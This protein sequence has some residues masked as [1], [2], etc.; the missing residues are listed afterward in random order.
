MRD[1]PQLARGYLEIAGIVVRGA[2]AAGGSVDFSRLGS[3]AQLACLAA[4]DEDLDY[5][6]CELLEVS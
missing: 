3:F 5:L 4:F 1:F 2:L 6:V